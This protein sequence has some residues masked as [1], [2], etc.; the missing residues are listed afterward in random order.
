LLDAEAEHQPFS[1]WASDCGFNPDSIKDRAIW[2]ACIKNARKVR[3][4]FNREQI[5][6]LRQLLE[7]Y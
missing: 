5:K 2:E 3:G 4:I 7:D 6:H 1:D